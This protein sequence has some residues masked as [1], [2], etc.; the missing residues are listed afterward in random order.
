MKGKEKEKGKWKENAT[1]STTPLHYRPQGLCL[2]GHGVS[3]I[4]YWQTLAL[5]VVVL[6]GVGVGVWVRVRVCR[7]CGFVRP[8]APF[9]PFL[10][11]L[12]TPQI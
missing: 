2:L 12:C 8:V 3:L 5:I 4:T 11:T 7:V 10:Y 9:P 1:Q 6:I